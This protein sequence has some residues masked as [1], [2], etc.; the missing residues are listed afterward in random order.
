MRR[1]CGKGW[2][3]AGEEPRRHSKAKAFP[4]QVPPPAPAQVSPGQLDCVSCL[5][6]VSPGYSPGA[7]SPAT[8]R[9]EQASQEAA[10]WVRGAFKC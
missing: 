6:F 1:A 2:V 8:Q 9:K 3:R 10:G 7:K 5:L 4:L